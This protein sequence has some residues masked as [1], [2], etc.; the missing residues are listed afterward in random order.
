M[1]DLTLYPDRDKQIAAE[2]HQAG[3]EVVHHRP[4]VTGGISPKISGVLTRTLLPVIAFTRF[5]EYWKADGKVPLN[6]AIELYHD[7]HGRS[8]D[9]RVEGRQ[10]RD[11]Q[12]WAII[13]YEKLKQ[14]GLDINRITM[15]ELKRR[16]TQM[17][18]EIPYNVHLYHVYGQAGLNLFVAQL[19]VQHIVD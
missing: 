16:A 11:P 1:L 9:L 15:I 5:P 8:S 6:V 4:P 13:D 3:I 14:M 19:R 2:L 17:K 7:P 10:F 12:K 18:I